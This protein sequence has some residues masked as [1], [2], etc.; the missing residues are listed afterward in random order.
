MENIFNSENHKKSALSA[1]N[2]GYNCAQ[3][4][5][6]AFSDKLD[7]DK[8]TAISIS[9]GFGAGMGR[10]QKTCGAV[11]GSFMAIS[12]HC[13]KNSKDNATAKEIAIIKIREFNE[14]FIAKHATT[15]CRNLLGYDL[16]TPEGE[17]QY[18]RQGLR[19]SVCEACISDS[20]EILC[21]LLKP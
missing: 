9:S 15:D 10:L 20:V 11:T 14:S 4:V 6:I 8:S 18:Q 21:Q 19:K 17:Q 13:S 7:I 5:L 12:H 1:F 2:D 3:A 16:N